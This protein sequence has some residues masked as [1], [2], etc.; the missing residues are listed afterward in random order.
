[1]SKITLDKWQRD[2]LNCE[3]HVLLCTGRQVGKTT[4]FAIKAAEYMIK[5]RDSS[6]IVV[7]LTEDQA[8]LMI[9]KILDYLERNHRALIESGHLKPTKNKILL[10][11][12]SS[13]LARPVGNTGAAVRGFTGDV[14]IVD[15]A[16]RMPE[17][18]WAAAKPTL[19]TTG[20][21][22]W[23]CSTPHGKQGYFYECFVNKSERFTV[24]HVNSEEVIK[25]RKITHN[26]T[27]RNREEAL[28]FL[29]DEKKDM[30]MLQYAQEYLGEFIDDLRQFFPDELIQKCMIAERQDSI[31][32]NSN[33]YLGV[34]VA[35][36]G[37]DESTFEIFERFDDEVI[38]VESQIKQRTYLNEITK[39][40]LELDKIY[41]FSKI[42]IDDGGIGVGVFD[43]LITDEQTRRKTVA[44]NNNK[45]VIEYDP[46]NPVKKRL[47]KED[48]YNNLLRL[49]EQGKIK[50]LKDP[51]IFQSLK[52][53]QYEYFK[54]EQ[55]S[56]GLHIFGN[57]THIVE[58]IIRA[59]WCVKEKNLNIWIDTIN[60][61]F[62]R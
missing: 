25:N 28:K 60:H 50:L 2:V 54:D 8:Q 16:S 47:L 17:L 49:M 4:I 52:S 7:S 36:M 26:W 53:V 32:K 33:Y 24:F 29:N 12:K 13:V 20:G 34:D 11:N 58:G 41:N 5:H 9:M 51:N 43:Y 27:Q 21:E 35:R 37:D 59:V 39:H 15:E 40:V 14:L 6:I 46:I 22:L 30:S 44:I 10:K 19:L 18:M 31:S 42:Y 56:G 55:H 61:G 23:L 48:L 45:R 1:M 62:I 38:H 57:Y 3:G